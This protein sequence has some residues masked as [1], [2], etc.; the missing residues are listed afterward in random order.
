MIIRMIAVE[1][2]KGRFVNRLVRIHLLSAGINK[3]DLAV[4]SFPVLSAIEPLSLLDQTFAQEQGS[5]P[6]HPLVHFIRASVTRGGMLYLESS[7]PF[8]VER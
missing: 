8:L 4:C 6:C 7:A 5:P 2:L 1:P 3:L